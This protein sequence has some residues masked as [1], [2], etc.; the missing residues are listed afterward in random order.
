[1]EDIVSVSARFFF[2]YNWKCSDK[3]S[4]RLQHVAKLIDEPVSSHLRYFSLNLS[5]VFMLS[6]TSLPFKLSLRSLIAFHL[7]SPVTS[8]FPVRLPLPSQ[9]FSPV[10]QRFLAVIFPITDTSQIINL[11]TRFF[12][13]LICGVKSLASFVVILQAMTALLTPHA[14]PRLVLL[15][16]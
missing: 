15:G 11:S 8:T 1:V 9:Q 7:P 12:N 5:Q 4:M 3:Q 13:S 2:R 14:R 6:S 16:T 10:R